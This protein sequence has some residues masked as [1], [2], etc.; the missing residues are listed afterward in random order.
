MA[1]EIRQG[2]SDDPARA[3]LDA[4]GEQFVESTRPVR[5]TVA[6]WDLGR[7]ESRVLSVG[8]R[9]PISSDNSAADPF[10]QFCACRSSHRYRSGEARKV[11]FLSALTA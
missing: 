3:W 9:R 8:V 5:E 6:A 1:E 10:V 11:V 4:E 2:P 7:G